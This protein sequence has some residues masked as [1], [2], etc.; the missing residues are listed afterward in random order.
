MPKELI[1]IVCLFTGAFQPV[2]GFS[3]RVTH[4]VDEFL[5]ASAC[6]GHVSY[7]I[8][9]ECRRIER[10]IHWVRRVS[11]RQPS[12]QRRAE[13]QWHIVQVYARG[14]HKLSKRNTRIKSAL[15]RAPLIT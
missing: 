4:P 11:A 12:E 9:D 5:P 14:K 15:N 1:A 3:Q 8:H 2:D 7:L 10:P 13:F 6:Q